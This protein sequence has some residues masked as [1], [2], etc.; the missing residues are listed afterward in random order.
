LKAFGKN[1][2]LYYPLIQKSILKND[3][4]EKRHLPSLNEHNWDLS[5]FGF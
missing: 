1:K 2:R 3:Y 4:S 5:F